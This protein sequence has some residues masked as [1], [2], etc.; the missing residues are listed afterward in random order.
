M[1]VLHLL[2]CMLTVEMRFVR[3][4]LLGLQAQWAPLRDLCSQRRLLLLLK[5]KYLSRVL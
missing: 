5:R 1:L 3:I 4:L 2:L